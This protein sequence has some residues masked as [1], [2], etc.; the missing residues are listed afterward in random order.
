MAVQGLCCCEWAFCSCSEQ[1]LLF[2][3]VCKLIVVASLSFLIQHF[4]KGFYCSLQILQ[5]PQENEV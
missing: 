1:E 5:V 3:A 4:N 2:V